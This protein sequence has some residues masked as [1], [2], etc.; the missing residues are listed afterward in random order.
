MRRKNWKILI[1]LILLTFG[2]GIAMYYL[3]P[4]FPWKKQKAIETAQKYVEKNYSGDVAM[5]GNIEYW[6]H[7]GVYIQ[8]FFDKKNQISFSVM[9]TPSF[10]PEKCRDT[11]FYELFLKNERNR[12]QTIAN[13]CNF[14]DG[15]IKVHLGNDFRDAYNNGMT[16][17]M[18][19][20]RYKPFYWVDIKVPCEETKKQ[21][22]DVDY[23][24]VQIMNC[25]EK[26]YKITIEYTD[27]TMQYTG[28]EVG[29]I[30]AG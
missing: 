15:S 24:L 30:E 19:I 9:I 2:L 1:I 11:Y 14:T 10:N 13:N 8:T 23:F 18:N 5:K 21:K 17:E 20:S 3:N 28:K 22:E 7:D 29:A 26:P 25:D 16:Y 4:I 6:R 27:K 12:I